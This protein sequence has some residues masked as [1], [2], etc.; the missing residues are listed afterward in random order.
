MY[1]KSVARTYFRA[2]TLGVAVALLFGCG[3]DNGS[4]L[5]EQPSSVLVSESAT[6]L[7]VRTEMPSGSKMDKFE[8]QA[9]NYTF[10]AQINSGPNAG[11]AITG[12]M[13]LKGERE[14]DGV[15]E[16]RRASLSRCDAE[17]AP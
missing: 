7:S 4:A 2:S 15:T 8:A 14:D 5:N 1:Q 16:S 11:L 17:R 3:G 10:A 13:E 6:I 9:L 12:R